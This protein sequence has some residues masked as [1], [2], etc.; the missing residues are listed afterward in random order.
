MKA[1][2]LLVEDNPHIMKINSEALA[3]HGYRVLEAETLAEGRTLF[4]AEK[5]DLIL[6]DIMLP[7]GNGLDF[8][9]ELR[10]QQMDT[11]ILFL[12]AMNEN[13]DIVK[14]LQAGGDDY[15]TKPYHYDVLLARVE[16]LLRRAARLR[17][18]ESRV[19]NLLILHEL[20]RATCN[21]V[22]L[23]LTAKEFSVLE[24]LARSP[25]KPVPAG[26][27]HKA[28]W[29]TAAKEDSSA[30]KTHISRLRCKLEAVG[31]TAIICTE[32]GKGYWLA[33]AK[34]GENAPESENN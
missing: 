28:L 10:A 20:H 30:V 4:E 12:T 11:P 17:P 29:G 13:S 31:A 33:E 3:L 19:G 32:R 7:D 26:V 34:S 8:C 16:A 24:L 5:P 1:T 22:D 27:L 23:R 9:E 18:A 6:L 14:G 2:I 25:G 15:I 21:D